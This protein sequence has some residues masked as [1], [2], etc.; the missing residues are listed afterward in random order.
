[1]RRV[2]IYFLIAVIILS[3]STVLPGNMPVAGGAAGSADTTEGLVQSKVLGFGNGNCVEYSPDGAMLAVSASTGIYILDAKTFENIYTLFGHGES[4]F[5]L[6]W[7]PDGKRLVSSS[8]DETVRIWDMET[9]EC[10][11]ILSDENSPYR[12][13]SWSPDGNMISVLITFYGANNDLIILDA[14]SFEQVKSFNFYMNGAT[15]NS[16]SHDSTKLAVGKEDGNV[17]IYN[18]TDWTRNRV[19]GQFQR[20]VTSLTWSH[21]DSLIAA[22]DSLGGAIVWN[23]SDWGEV[24]SLSGLGFFYE[25]E[26]S[27][28][29]RFLTTA[30]GR[31]SIFE[32]WDT[33]SWKK[34]TSIDLGEEY[35]LEE[36]SWSPDG[37]NLATISSVG[38]YV[39]E[40]SN[41]SIVYNLKPEFFASYG[42]AFNP[43][44]SLCAV[45]ILIE[46]RDWND[47]DFG[48]RIYDTKEWTE[49]KSLGP[50]SKTVSDITW[51]PDGGFLAFDSYEGMF[52]ILQTDSWDLFK[53]LPSKYGNITCLSYSPDGNFLL[54][55][56][57]YY[58][59]DQSN[60][61]VLVNE[62]EI[63]DTFSWTVRVIETNTSVHKLPSWSPDGS[64]LLV[65]LKNE[66]VMEIYDLPG[67]ELVKTVG[68]FDFKYLR[69]LSWSPDGATLAAGTNSYQR[70]LRLYDTNSWNNYQNLSVPRISEEMWLRWSPDG[71]RLAVGPFELYDES[72][73]QKDNVRIQVWDCETWEISQNLAGH[74]NYVTGF[75][76]HPDSK[77]LVSTSYDGLIIIWF[78]KDHITNEIPVIKIKSPQNGERIKENIVIQGT[79]DDIESLEYVQVK[80]G[81]NGSWLIANG[82]SE[83][84][85]MMDSGPYIN[86]V[87]PIYARAFDGIIYSFPVEVGVFVEIDDNDN[88]GISDLQD[89]DDDNDGYSDTNEI[90]AGTDPFDPTSIPA[91]TDK[92]WI[93][94][95]MDIDIDNDGHKN[96]EDEYPYDKTKW[97]AKDYRNYY[98]AIAVLL[99]ISLMVLMILL[100]RKR[101]QVED[102]TR[103]ENRDEE[104]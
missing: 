59:Q 102:N 93:P 75:A 71:T 63:W 78:D 81:V 76:W 3:S 26:F 17:E 90:I 36:I 1:M 25:L 84:T 67:F 19:V 97:E 74:S 38:I 39:L 52:T 30:L 6:S 56:S 57:Y 35:Y 88:D 42:P 9:G 83:W 94:D 65:G 31:D 47:R 43:D 99:F 41:W 18:T 15:S 86:E 2:T 13:S 79:A 44:G 27:P 54:C 82:T 45:G 53:E 98:L 51:S 4:V 24:K 12:K 92:D 80:V 103:T 5:F 40:T 66:N 55:M 10:I 73:S 50:F 96:D 85:F 49:K 104:D 23:T 32:L 95:V 20:Y 28:D 48:L 70:I 87:V 14:N 101:N 100:I 22:S 77:R 21:D 64:R 61:S 68:S 58:Y 11:K 69:D 33:E 29:D 8:F 46:A 72:D 37:K 89:N 16:W 91:D 62:I 34:N 7:S 60:K